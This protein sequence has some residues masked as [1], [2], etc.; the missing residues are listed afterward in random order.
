MSEGVLW[1]DKCRVT[2]GAA[3]ADPHLG[4]SFAHL[5]TGLFRVKHY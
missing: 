2:D 1:P 5:F 3:M 4:V